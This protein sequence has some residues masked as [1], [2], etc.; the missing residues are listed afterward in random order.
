MA[1]RLHWLLSVLKEAGKLIIKSI[2]TLLL[3]MFIVL[4]GE[5]GAAYTQQSTGV[6]KK[7]KKIYVNVPKYSVCKIDW[8][9]YRENTSQ[10]FKAFV[11]VI[12][13]KLSDREM[14]ERW[15]DFV[16]RDL[17]MKILNNSL[18]KTVVIAP[19]GMA[20]EIFSTVKKAVNM[21]SK[22]EDGNLYLYKGKKF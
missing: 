9:R 10:K 21:D 19:M 22:F 13:K 16:T 20:V 7:T 1:L 3:C 4:F 5:G 11:K 17:N 2:V 18:M 15:T 12:P 6:D 14:L 8:D